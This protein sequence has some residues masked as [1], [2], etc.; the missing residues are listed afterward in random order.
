MKNKG[1]VFLCFTFSQNR[2][3]CAKYIFPIGPSYVSV[4]TSTDTR[5]SLLL[6]KKHPLQLLFSPRLNLSSARALV[7]CTFSE[8]E[9]KIFRKNWY[10]GDQFKENTPSLWLY[11]TQ[12]YLVGEAAID[13]HRPFCICYLCYMGGL[14]RGK[15]LLW[16][17]PFTSL[18][19]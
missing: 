9:R 6:L 17:L 18:F 7:I 14:P 15:L 2:L 11:S 8:T 5:N 10:G 3:I 13:L 12:R 1:L 4:Y 19:A 16:P